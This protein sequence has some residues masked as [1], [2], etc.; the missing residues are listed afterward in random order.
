VVFVKYIYER[1]DAMLA[2]KKG[3]IMGIVIDN[4]I[5]M[6]CGR[7]LCWEEKGCYVVDLRKQKATAGNVPPK[8]W[9]KLANMLGR[10]IQGER[11]SILAQ[12]E[13][14]VLMGKG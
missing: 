7:F 11:E 4:C 2:S 12:D 13:I 6:E 14:N 9:I 8:E 3:E 10:K 1:I 5:E